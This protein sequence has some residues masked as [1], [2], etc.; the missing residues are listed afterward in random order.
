MGT[1]AG[2]HSPNSLLSMGIQ[3]TG[4]ICIGSTDGQ[5]ELETMAMGQDSRSLYKKKRRAP[6]RI[7][8]TCI[9]S[10]CNHSCREIVRRLGTI[11]RGIANAI[12]YMEGGDV[13]KAFLCWLNGFRL[14]FRYPCL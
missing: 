1:T 4:R 14:G 11:L 2:I 7:S 6:T 10:L 5:R 3:R 13:T 12:A 8:P 9:C